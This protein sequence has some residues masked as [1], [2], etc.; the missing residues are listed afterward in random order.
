MN[1]FSTKHLLYFFIILISISCS[2]NTGKSNQTIN[3][4]KDSAIILNWIGH[5]LAREGKEQMVRN[6]AR[7]YEFLNQKTIVNLKFPTE[8]IKDEVYRPHLV[9]LYV[10]MIQTGKVDWDIILLDHF[11]YGQIAAQLG[12]PFWGDKYLVDFESFD[13]F[14]ESH[15]PFI[16]QDP[17]YRNMT[18]GKLVGPFIE[19]FYT[20]FWYNKKIAAQIGLKVK[21][22]G[23]TF[24][25]LK[26]Y[27]KLGFEYN[28][29]NNEKITLIC[30]SDDASNAMLLTALVV[31]DLKVVDTLNFADNLKSLKKGLDALEEL[32]VYKPIELYNEKNDVDMILRGNGLFVPMSSWMYN[33]WKIVSKVGTDKLIPAELPVFQK[34]GPLYQGTYQSVFAVFKNSPHKE[35]AID[36]LKYWC[37][38]E[39]A[40]NWLSTTK[41]PTGLKVQLNSTDLKQ[42]EIDYFNYT[43][44]KKFGHNLFNY[45]VFQVL[46]GSKNRNIR[47]MQSEILNGT[48]TSK[49]AY[50]RILKQ[51]KR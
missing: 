42:D 17:F 25:D 11:L 31:S 47:F 28:Q 32:A 15:K 16:I 12:D 9:E 26:D 44:D 35:Q 33:R 6:I 29:K 43:I 19:G 39:N 21:N 8:F 36:L 5:W 40:E 20:A 41:N 4:K 37:R 49:E 50:G 7:E 27:L 45:S 24:E 10:K 1:N 18:G 51:L 46:L 22:T 48:S 30:P 13:W 3:A 14:K 2:N 34:D 23:M 38:Q